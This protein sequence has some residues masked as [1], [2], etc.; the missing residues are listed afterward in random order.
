MSQ[1][2][3]ISANEAAEKWNISHRRVNTLCSENRIPNVV[4][5]GQMW[6]IPVDSEKP[7]DGRT[8]KYDNLIKAKPFVKWAGGKGQLLPDIRTF[9]PTGM[10]TTIKRYCEPMVG[11]G[12]VL[13]DVVNSF[14]MEEVI[15]NDANINLINT[16]RII[17][18]QVDSLIDLL[19]E[20]EEQYLSLDQD[21]QKSFFYKKREQFNKLIMSPNTDNSLLRAALFIFLNKTCF[22]GLYR[23]NKR[24]EFNVP[25]GSYK[26][27]TICDKENLLQISNKLNSVT[28]TDGDYST[29]K[30]KVDSSTFVYFDPPYR[31]LSKTASFT[32]YGADSFT[33]EQQI[34]L[35]KFIISLAERDVKVMASNSDPK[36]TDEMDNFFDDLY[37]PLS[38]HR[39]S[40]NRA[41][42]SKGS[43]RGK[44]NELLIT[45]YEVE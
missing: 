11:A 6:L 5:I 40:A 30:S 33:D 24:G 4:K 13:F 2:Q 1:V 18:K 38:I 25:I 45:S 14:D 29:I 22:N 31:P 20:M 41:I 32:A 23:V 16:Y 26:K 15:I 19:D 27:P 34:Q 39:L 3:Y 35:G 12:A 28:I 43:G 7:I 17:Q 44:I 21:E 36:N 10:G 9:Y 8:K 37:A 42:N